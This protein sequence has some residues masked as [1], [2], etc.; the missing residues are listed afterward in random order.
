MKQHLGVHLKKK[1]CE[2]EKLKGGKCIES[3]RFLNRMV[4]SGGMMNDESEMS[5][6][7]EY[8]EDQLGYAENMLNNYERFEHDRNSRNSR[9]GLLTEEEIRNLPPPPPDEDEEFTNDLH[10]M[11]LETY[12]QEVEEDRRKEVETN[13]SEEIRG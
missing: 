4:L 2:Y 6:D 13:R 5:D 10:E 12:M 9:F 8:L 7:E 1:L 3:R 11:N